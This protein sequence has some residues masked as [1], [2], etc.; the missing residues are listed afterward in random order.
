M[1]KK[2]GKLVLSR[3]TL[4][5]LDGFRNALG[6]GTYNCTARGYNCTLTCTGCGTGAGSDACTA[7]Q[8]SALCE[9]GGACTVTCV[10]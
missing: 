7:T 6:A 4:G 9:T 1:K 5:S 10:C 2:I 8:C 3:E